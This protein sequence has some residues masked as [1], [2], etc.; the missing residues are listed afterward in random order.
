MAERSVDRIAGEFDWPKFD[1]AEQALFRTIGRLA[2]EALSYGIPDVLGCDRARYIGR[3]T[4]VVGA[5]HSAANVLFDLD[6]L[7]ERDPATTLVRV[8][9]STNLM[10]VVGGGGWPPAASSAPL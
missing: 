1:P 4:L 10:R 5:G 2:Q 7:V 8:T 6:R 9:R 3:T